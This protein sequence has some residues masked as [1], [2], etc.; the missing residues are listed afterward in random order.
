ME[1]RADS[2]VDGK[3]ALGRWDLQMQKAD[4]AGATEYYQVLI[5]PV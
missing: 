2:D 1:K 5:L 3:L 4:C